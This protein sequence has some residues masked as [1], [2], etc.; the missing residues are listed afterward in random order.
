MF[1]MSRMKGP[2]I[3]RIFGTRSKSLFNDFIWILC[4]HSLFQST[5][6]LFYIKPLIVCFLFICHFSCKSESNTVKNGNLLYW[7]SRPHR[8][9]IM[10]LWNAFHTLMPEASAYEIVMKCNFLNRTRQDLSIDR[11]YHLH[12][13]NTANV[14]G[15]CFLRWWIRAF[16]LYF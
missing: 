10:A 15:V 16:L 2:K 5:I 14:S 8:G 13:R 7:V 11:N 3:F 6:C 4:E 1:C 9:A 12:L